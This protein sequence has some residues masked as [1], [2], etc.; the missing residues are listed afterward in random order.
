MTLNK[1][2]IKRI[3]VIRRNRVGD[4][5][6]AIPLIKTLKKEFPHARLVVLGEEGNT[7]ILKG[8]WCVD[9]IWT[10]RSGKGLF[11][12]KYLGYLRFL[13]KKEMDFDLAIGVKPGFSSLLAFITLM[14]G[15]RYRIGC[16]L[17][18]WHILNFC[19]NRPVKINTAEKAEHQ[20]E[21]CLNLLKAV[22]IHEPVRDIGF[23]VERD[24]IVFAE[25]FF[26]AHKIKKGERVAVFN[27]SNNRSVNLW[28]EERFAEV[29]RFI[30]GKYGGW[31]VITAAPDDA[32]RAHKICTMIGAGAV[33][34]RTPSIMDYA[35]IIKMSRFLLCSE[36]GAMH[37]AAALNV[38]MIALFGRNNID[39]WLPYSQEYTILSGK[40]GAFSISSDEVIQS[41]R[42][43]FAVISSLT[44]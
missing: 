15:A 38:P 17:K 31:C 29:G 9:E 11:R 20:I 8:V 5:I 35:A 42:K 21:A 30:T 19:Y 3:L 37:V 25:Q 39:H 1:E 12:N 32:R 27:V 13:I 44:S 10:Y 40:D 18:K 7:D 6:C 26:D 16:R 33:F 4:M 34:C 43:R 36:G 2:E 28:A 23:E 14:S 24:K 41:I 22:D